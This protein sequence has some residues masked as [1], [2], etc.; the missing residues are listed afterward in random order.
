MLIQ[1]AVHTACR[2]CFRLRHITVT[3]FNT[4]LNI[5]RDECKEKIDGC[6]SKTMNCVNKI[7]SFICVCKPGFYTEGNRYNCKGLFFFCSYYH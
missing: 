7:P 6:P 4:S 5:D 1:S 3:T 2:K